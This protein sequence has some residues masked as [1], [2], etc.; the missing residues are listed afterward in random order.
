L[1]SSCFKKGK[2]SWNAGLNV[3]GMSGKS[4][5]PD[6]LKK[7]SEAHIALHE[8]PKTK[9]EIRLRRRGEYKRW[10]MAVFERDGY[11]CVFCKS[12]ENLQAD[13]IL[14]FAT[15]EDKR[16]DVSNGRTLCKPCHLNT[17]SH[18]AS[19]RKQAIRA[20]IGQPFTKI[21]NGDNGTA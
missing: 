14:P 17:E 18:G 7:M 3:S 16:L 5:N 15:C 4:H 9:L 10:R 13:H 19:K 6:T 1:P 21:N 11:K 8:E 20:E 12:T 2:Q